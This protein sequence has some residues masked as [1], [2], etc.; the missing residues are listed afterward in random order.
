MAYIPKNKIITNLYSNNGD[1]V[2]ANN[3]N[4]IGPYYRLYNGRTFTGQTPNSP[5]SVEIFFIGNIIPLNSF[6]GDLS[7]GDGSAPGIIYN[8]LSDPLVGIDPIDQTVVSPYNVFDILPIPYNPVLP[9]VKDYSNKEFVRYF[10]VKRNEPF[11]TEISKDTYDLYKKQSPNVPWRAFKVFTLSWLLTGDIIY[12]AK[13]NKNITELTE[14]RESAPGLSVYLKNNWIQYFR[15]S[16]ADNLYTDGK[17]DLI[18][19]T[20]TGQVY[21]GPYHIHPDKGYMAGATHTNATHESLSA[22]YQ[23]QKVVDFQPYTPPKPTQS[24]ISSGMINYMSGDIR[25]Y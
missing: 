19:K 23:G 4:Y 15:F 10:N 3:S 5:N 12:V 9:T 13:T 25:G 14:F 8:P 24:S 21:I 11:F 18:L 1:F 20:H 16:E 7:L 17:S 2:L 22:Y 6:E